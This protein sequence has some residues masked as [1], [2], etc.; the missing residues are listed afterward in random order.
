MK[1]KQFAVIGLGR[2]GRALVEELNKM[3]YEVL[4]IDYNEDR[5]HDVIDAATQAVQADATD[6]QAL[7]SLDIK[8]FDVAIVSIGENIQANILATIM[9]KELGVKRVVAKAHNALHGKVLEKIGADL[10]IY[11]ERD[12]GIKLARSLVSQNILDQIYLSPGYSIMEL[13]TPKVFA[14]K[15]LA[16]IGLRNKM[17]I[18]VLA[19]KRGEEIIVAP[20]A[21][22]VIQAGD[23]LV[24]IG[25]DEDLQKLIEM[26]S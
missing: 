25:K 14:G 18:T 22:Q 7:K 15:S 10:V 17:G 6:E 13:V 12:M 26:E 19:V 24:A 3:G 1:D 23:V 11:P 21:N 2:F 4:A 9:L 20:L 16:D 5:V 8:D